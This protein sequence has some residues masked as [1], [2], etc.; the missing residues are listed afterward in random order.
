MRALL[1]SLDGSRSI[2]G[3]MAEEPKPGGG[4][5]RAEVERIATSLGEKLG[6]QMLDRGAGELIGRE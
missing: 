4:R 6:E 3:E 2:S 1:F 5:S